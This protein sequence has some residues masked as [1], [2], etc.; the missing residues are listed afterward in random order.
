MREWDDYLF[1][2]TRER[3]CVVDAVSAFVVPTNSTVGP[4]GPVT[5]SRLSRLMVFARFARW[6]KLIDIR[7]LT[8]LGHFVV[9]TTT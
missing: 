8:A 3:E 7:G 4:R 6:V 9:K 5:L 1:R 2:L